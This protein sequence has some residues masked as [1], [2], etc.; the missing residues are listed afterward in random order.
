[1]TVLTNIKYVVDGKSGGGKKIFGP[2]KKTPKQAPP[3]T[4]TMNNPSTSLKKVETT[5]LYNH[6]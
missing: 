3:K 5:K 6:S 1:M 4:Y 2:V